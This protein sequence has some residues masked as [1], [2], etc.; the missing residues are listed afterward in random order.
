MRP[1]FQSVL[2][3]LFSAALVGCSNSG[4]EA[5]ADADGADD[6][7]FPWWGT[8]SP[9]EPD[10]DPEPVADEE[11]GDPDWF[12]AHCAGGHCRVSDGFDPIAYLHDAAALCA[13]ET[14]LETLG[15]QRLWFALDERVYADEVR[16]S[17]AGWTY[18]FA[19]PDPDDLWAYRWI[20]CDVQVTAGDVVVDEAFA[21]DSLR[22]VAVQDLVDGVVFGIDHALED[23]GSWNGVTRGGIQWRRGMEAPEVFLADD[24]YDDWDRWDA[25]TGERDW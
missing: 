19:T 17:E 11:P 10:G 6:Q 15:F 23:F 12:D 14:G 20:V 8:Y 1:L 9:G 2:I 4:L 22:T 3:V 21:S 24:R 13:D 25:A 16:F 7:A 5:R 18:R